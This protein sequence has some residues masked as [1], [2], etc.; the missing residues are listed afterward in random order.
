M[1]DLATDEVIRSIG[2]GSTERLSSIF[3]EIHDARVANDD[4]SRNDDD[5]SRETSDDDKEE[6]GSHDGEAENPADQDHLLE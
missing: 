6:K 4:G 5:S 1:A 2:L 3:A